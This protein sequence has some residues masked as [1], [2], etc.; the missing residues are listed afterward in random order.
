[1]NG[2]FQ[3]ND[4]FW[5]ALLDGHINQDLSLTDPQVAFHL[6]VNTMDEAMGRR[7]EKTFRAWM[8]HPTFDDFWQRQAY[9]AHLAKVT[10]PVLHLDGWYDYRDISATLHNYNFMI[11]EGGSPEA[12]RNQRVVIGPWAHGGYDQRKHGDIDF[13]PDSVIDRKALFLSWYD[14][15][16]EKKNCDRIASQPPVRIFV[17]GENHWRDEQEWPLRRA[18]PTKYYLHSEGHAN[19]SGGDGRLSLAIPAAE[20]ADHYSYD[21][22][23]PN[24][25]QMEP[26]DSLSADQRKAEERQNMLVFTSETLEAPLEVSG[27]IQVKLWTAS[28]ARDTDWVARLIDVHPDD[29]AQRLTDAI[30]RAKYHGD[31]EYPR[32]PSEFFLQSPGVAREY[33]LDLWDISHVF[34]KGHRIRVEIASG[35]LPLFSRNLNTGEDNLTTTKTQTAEQTVY[36]DAEHP[37]Y[38]T[39]P[40]VPMNSRAHPSSC[41]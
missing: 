16:L 25:I 36:H 4:I 13:G 24:V 3:I 33:T 28:S 31:S 37:S 35:F 18:Q 41:I 2:A 21:P 6:P 32:S 7:L 34:L 12:R 15:H 9:T 27:P 11:R 10:V 39:L 38:I 14:C 19:S 1:V 22:R 17:M 23:D 8:E 29:Y 40:I 20:R 26:G 30:V 5:C